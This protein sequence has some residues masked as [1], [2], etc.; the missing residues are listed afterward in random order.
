MSEKNLSTFL[1]EQCR[2]YRKIQGLTQEELAVRLNTTA[3]TVS[4]YERQGIK[5]V[6][7]EEAVA[8]ALGVNLREETADKEGTVGEVGK[9]ILFCLL[10]NGG[11]CPVDTIIEKEMYGMS[12]ERVNHEIEKIAQLDMCSRDNYVDFHG[13]KKDD[14]FITAKGII[15]YKNLVSDSFHEKKLEEVL[16][17]VVSYEMALSPNR[18][19]IS[20]CRLSSAKDMEEYIEM[21]PWISKIYSLNINRNFMADFIAYLY[22]VWTTE[23]SSIGHYVLSRN[24]VNILFPGQNIYHDIIY[25]MAYGFSNEWRCKWLLG[26]TADDE[27]IKYGELSEEEEILLQKEAPEEFIKMMDEVEEE[28]RRDDEENE[29]NEKNG[30]DPDAIWHRDYLEESFYNEFPWVYDQDDKETMELVKN[31]WPKE[32]RDM[33]SL[34]CAA[35]RKTYNANAPKGKEKC[36]PAEWFSKEE[37]EAFIRENYKKPRNY[38][39]R[40]MLS[41]L[42]EINKV[43]PQALWFYFDF[44]KEWEENGL[45]DLVRELCCVE[46]IESMSKSE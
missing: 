14:L 33:C 31:F 16:P 4:N 40:K 11:K 46:E 36:F 2:K 29:Y 43:L 26:E 22:R 38:K 21:R 13:K 44:P 39:E 3:Q 37:I 25:R 24:E 45:A 32:L 27:N 9:E 23:F 19:E 5:D 10:E 12:K 6:D 15:T 42:V 34:N 28:S 18:N 20:N 7:T 35:R 41:T 8:K 30:I 17:K 1:G